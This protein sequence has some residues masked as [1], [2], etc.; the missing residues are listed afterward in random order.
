MGPTYCHLALL[1]RTALL[2]AEA[3][4]YREIRS[5]SD[6]LDFLREELSQAE[7]AWLFHRY[8]CAICLSSKI[9]EFFAGRNHGDQQQSVPGM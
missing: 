7:T 3:N 4:L 5:L 2:E 1:K 6:T 8:T 9:R